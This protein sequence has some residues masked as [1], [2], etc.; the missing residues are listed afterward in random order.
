ML[1]KC[2]NFLRILPVGSKRTFLFS[3]LRIISRRFP[4]TADFIPGKNTTI[5]ERAISGVAALLCGFRDIAS[6]FEDHLV[7]WILRDG[8]GYEHNIQRAAT[9][10]LSRNLGKDLSQV[11]GQ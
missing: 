11:Y 10:A 7:E 5:L 4:F 8:L 1:H 9:A 6:D 2:S 3:L